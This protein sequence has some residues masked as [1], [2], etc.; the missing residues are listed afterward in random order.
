RVRRRGRRARPAVNDRRRELLDG[1]LRNEAD[2]AFRRRLP[3]LLDYL[4][5]RDGDRVLDC[6]CGMGF[7][8]MVM[9]SL[10]QLT[11]VGLDSDAERLRWAERERVP[12]ELVHGDAER[13]PFEDESFDAVLMSEVLEHLED[14][15]RALAEARRVLRC[16]GRLAVSVPHARYPLLWDP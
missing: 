3:I 6:G 15:G 8:L 5:L 2:M 14:D 13:L 11:L 7:H 10:W 1:L 9:S 12:A 16:G 4:E